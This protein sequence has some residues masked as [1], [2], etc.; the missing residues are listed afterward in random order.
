[1]EDVF[2]SAV[3]DSHRS[4]C[5]SPIPSQTY[6]N[7]GGRGLGG[8]FGYFIYETD[9]R[10]PDG[11]IDLIGKAASIEA[12]TRLFELLTSGVKAST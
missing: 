10:H 5:I 7:C 4:I 3:I 9:N 6:A 1:M 11:G 8:E 2:L 12:A